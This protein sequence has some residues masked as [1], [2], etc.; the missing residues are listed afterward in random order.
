MVNALGKSAAPSTT[1]RFT[2]DSVAVVDN[3]LD[4][5]AC[6]T[7]REPLV[8]NHI[9]L[10]KDVALA[11]TFPLSTASARASTWV[12]SSPNADLWSKSNFSKR[13]AS[14]RLFLPARMC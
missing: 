13:P 10:S 6:L 12:W 7:P 3:K 8:G 4:H 1:C 11:G 9:P 5:A 2:W 14:Y